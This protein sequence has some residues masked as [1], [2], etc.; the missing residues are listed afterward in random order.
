MNMK[1]IDAALEYFDMGLKPIPLCWPDENGQCGCHKKH[2]KPKEIGKAPLL[3]NGYE[4]IEVTEERIE[5]WWSKWPNA[6]IGIL[7]EPSNLLVV[8]MD[9]ETAVKEGQKR[10]PLAPTLQSG[11]GEHRWFL[12]PGI[13]TR[14]TKRGKSRQ[15]DLLSSGYTIAPPSKHRNGKHYTWTVYPSELSSSG[16]DLD[17]PPDD[18]TLTMQYLAN[19][20]KAFTKYEFES[21]NL[22]K[23]NVR[24]EPIS[25][26]LKQLIIDGNVN[27]KHPSRSE[28]QFDAINR[29]IAAG[30]DPEK[31]GSVLLDPEYRIGDKIQERGP[32]KAEEFAAQEIARAHSTFDPTP[33][34]KTKRKKHLS[35]VPTANA[36]RKPEPIEDIEREDH[37]KV[38]PFFQKKHIINITDQPIHTLSDAAWDA[39]L[40]KN[41]PPQLFVRNWMMTEI[42]VDEMGNAKLMEVTKP[43]LRGRLD[44]YAKWMKWKKKGEGFDEVPTQPPLYVVEDMLHDP[45]MPLPEINGITHAPVFS[46]S[47][48]CKTTPG[49][50]P[51]SRMYYIDGNS[52]EIPE[53]SEEPSK[54]EVIEALD[55][56]VNEVLI[57]FPF[58]DRASR[59][60]SLAAI[61]LPFCR[62]MVKGPTPLHL[63]DAPKRGTGKSLLARAIH[64]IATGMDAPVDKFPKTEE[65]T[66]KKIVS[67]L[68][69]GRPIVVLD[70]ASGSV[71][72]DSLNAVLTSTRY[73]GRILGKSEMIDLQNFVTW[74]M[75]GNN[76]DLNGDIHRRVVWIRLD[77]GMDRPY[78]RRNR[79]FQH[80]DLLDWI[81]ENRSQILW[82]VITL[83]QNWVAKGKPASGERLGSFEGWSKVL[84]GILKAA[85]VDGFLEN[86][87]ELFD[88]ADQ[89]GLMWEEF[90]Q[91]WWN[92]YQSK[93]ITAKDLWK[94]A[95]DADMLHE[96]LGDGKENSQKI[97]MGKALQKMR[98]QFC[99]E[100]KIHSKRD[101]YRKTWT[102]YLKQEC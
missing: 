33:W 32:G 74:I 71:E 51:E 29:M 50:D 69:D 77:A 5:E 22:P 21:T 2:T 70:N 11:N 26:Y 92:K 59:V 66:D 7:L 10:L 67:I 41:D 61:F 87:D 31:I 101:N 36:V 80:P 64:M 46:P 82:A 30:W 98:D 37:A 56:L 86:K 3:G 16:V 97:R 52:L 35:L 6:N 89:E 85:G 34:E 55:L 75:T 68:K 4:N 102:Y 91:A 94:L 58:K 73:S 28:A 62:P 15:I 19:S 96:I 45:N 84:G 81:Q 78:A 14:S 76:V 9:G 43:A 72:R 17:L 39:L 90:C 13:F 24:S 83:I 99:G 1:M 57:D 18:I 8:D 47:G 44:R 12:S 79:E 53:V 38:H 23:V 65:E 95:T 88:M 48:K 40:E 25:S 60:H 63:I 54:N 27:G 93:A 49:Y 100:Y 42:R 20:K